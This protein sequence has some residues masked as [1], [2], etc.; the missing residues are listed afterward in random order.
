MRDKNVIVLDKDSSKIEVVQDIFKIVSREKGLLPKIRIAK[1]IPRILKDTKD[2][3]GG[4]VLSNTITK[5]QE[6]TVI[7]SR[8]KL[9]AGQK[10]KL[11]EAVTRLGFDGFI[12]SK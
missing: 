10:D 4:V 5:A 11:K 9:E 8:Q 6:I 1:L 12:K 2:S 7:C 3:Y